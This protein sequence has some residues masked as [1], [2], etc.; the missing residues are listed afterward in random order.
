MIQPFPFRFRH[1]GRVFLPP[2]TVE[3]GAVIKTRGKTGG[4]GGSD[5]GEFFSRR[6]PDR[7]IQQIAL[8]LHQVSVPGRPSVYPNLRDGGAGALGHGLHDIRDLIGDAVQGGPDDFTAAGGAGHAAKQ[9]FGFAVPVGSAQ[10][11]EGWNQIR[12]IAR[13]CRQREGFGFAGAVDQ[14]HIVL[15][16]GDDGTRII[17]I[18]LQHIMNF[19]ADFPGQGSDDAG[20]REDGLFS[21]VHHHGGTGAIGGFDHAGLQ[22]ALAEKGAVA[23]S[24]HAP[25][26]D[27][28]LQPAVQVRFPEIPVRIGHKGQA[29]SVNPEDFHQVR[30]PGQIRDVEKLGPGSVG[31][32][33]PV[34]PACGQ[35]PDQPA[36]DGADA[37]FSPGRGFAHAV[38]M[39]ENP[40]QLGG[41]KVGGEGEA[42]FP[43]YGFRKPLRFQ[44]G[45][46]FRSP[47]ALP[48]DSVVYGISRIPVPAD[49]GFALVADTHDRQLFPADSRLVHHVPDDLQ[50][51]PPDFLRVMLHP[52][53][54][55]HNLPVR[56]I[57]PGQDA[58]GQIENHGLGTL[59]ALVHAQNILIHTVTS[60][61]RRAPGR[62]SPFPAAY[63]MISGLSLPCSRCPR[64]SVRNGQKPRPRCP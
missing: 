46:D 2:G 50:G 22:A 54:F 62:E 40:G 12:G 9:R 30:I 44:F 38:H 64:P 49:G 21:D 5:A 3:N 18:S 43:L 35:F 47:G 15:Q 55:V 25:D 27:G 41:G 45:T 32:I 60:I 59:G 26:G 39:A 24:K 53:F 17:D 1:G 23:V 20:I 36:V 14:L 42:R 29:G 34:A 8:E 16:P 57:R 51:I 48:H 10:S 6:N 63:I 58:S 4:I 33:S 13:V 28:L 31:I 37:D 56:Q 7:D 52:A 11:G 61:K 19:S